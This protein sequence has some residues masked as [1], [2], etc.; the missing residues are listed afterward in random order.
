[1]GQEQ[2]E[3][4]SSHE[5]YMGIAEAV[6]RRAECVGYKIGAIIVSPENRVISTGYNGTPEGMDNCPDGC[7]RCKKRG[8]GG[9]FK[10]GEAYD[11]CICVHAEQNAVL[12]AARLGIAVKGATMY[13]TMT[14]CFGCAKELLQ[15]GIRKVYYRDEWSHPRINDDAD[16]RD[17]YKRLLGELH[18]QKV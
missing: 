4:P 7:I 11:L 12:S 18:C 10:S 14:P 15:A 13:T 6:R 8:E 9:T 3:R 16:L 2:G 5:Y 1:M 17:Q